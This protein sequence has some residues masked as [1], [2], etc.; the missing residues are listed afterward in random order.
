MMQCA[1][2]LAFSGRSVLYVSGE[3]SVSQIADRARRIRIIPR[4]ESSVF[5]EDLSSDKFRIAHESCFEVG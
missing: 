4:S 5:E 3:E 2:A 1:R